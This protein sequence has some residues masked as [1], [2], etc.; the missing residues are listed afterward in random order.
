MPFY[1]EYFSSKI[2]WQSLQNPS[3]P[4]RRKEKWRDLTLSLTL[5]AQILPSNSEQIYVLRQ[6]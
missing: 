5:L 6:R 2:Q 1:K 3:H 4:R